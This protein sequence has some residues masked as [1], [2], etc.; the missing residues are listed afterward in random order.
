MLAL[1]TA[2]LLAGCGGDATASGAPS[3][4]SS[5]PE[6]R[7]WRVATDCGGNAYVQDHG[8][9]I[10]FDTQGEEDS[11]YDDAPSMDV[12][13]CVLVGLDT[14]DYVLDHIDATR[15]LDGMQTDEWNGVMG[16][17]TYHPDD[18]LNLTLIDQRL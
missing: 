11:T 9:S 12:V 14:P 2:G 3:T 4:S 18:G 17:W 1:G 8:K 5:P 7:F 13:G 15:A 16:R 10:S 6:P